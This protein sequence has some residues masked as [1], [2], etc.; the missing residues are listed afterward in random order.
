MIIRGYADTPLGQIHFAECDS[1]APML[2]LHQTPR[3]WDEYRELLPLLG[4]RRRAI[5]MDT[6]G[7][8]QSA[9]PPEHSIE[10]YAAGALALLDALD[11]DQVD[12]LGHHTGG[13]VAIEVAACAPARVR[14]LVLSSTPFVDA[15]AR[16]RRRHRP[17]I[18]LVETQPD[19]R[20]LA[21]LWE[22]RRSFYPEGRPDLLTRFVRDA[23]RLQA[24]ELEAGHEAVGRYRMEQRLPL[25][26]CPVLCLG[27]SAD[28]YA[29]P[30][31][32]PLARHLAHATIT[33]VEG[34]MVPLMEER[35]SDVAAAVL[36]FL[37]GE[38]P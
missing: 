20:H 35:A 29:F 32:E 10:A 36:D 24:D 23:L 21:E 30:E 16:E 22:R 27:A 33:V 28:P 3:S 19:G 12:L 9:A 1:G 34:G 26:T 31:L 7:F 8:G 38:R 2:L 15:A 25:V 14:R 37:A 4:A 5:A 13:V 6:L 18:D 11:L 17:P